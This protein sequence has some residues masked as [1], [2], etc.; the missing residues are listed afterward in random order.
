MI[1]LQVVEVSLEIK[2]RVEAVVTRLASSVR[3]GRAIVFIIVVTYT[4]C[5]TLFVITILIIIEAL[6]EWC[7]IER[8]E[9][10]IACRVIPFD[11]FHQI[12]C[13]RCKWI[14]GLSLIILVVVVIERWFWSIERNDLK[15]DYKYWY[16][17]KR[18]II[19]SAK[20]WM[21]TG[22]ISWRRSK[23]GFQMV[24]DTKLW[25]I[26]SSYGQT[27]TKNYHAWTKLLKNESSGRQNESVDMIDGLA[28]VCG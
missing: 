7:C 2:P 9:S 18:N 20:W 25:K 3:L 6:V 16:N 10:N 5:L 21:D 13:E 28:V 15:L 12:T 19:G 8:I 14:G 17:E 24:L 11:R 26:W 23:A 4:I 1:F 22:W 27:N